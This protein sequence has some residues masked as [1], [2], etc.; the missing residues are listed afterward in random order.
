MYIRQDDMQMP[1]IACLSS[2]LEPP[3]DESSY[4][5]TGRYSGTLGIPGMHMYKRRRARWEGSFLDTVRR[6]RFGFATTTT[7]AVRWEMQVCLYFGVGDRRALYKTPGVW[8]CE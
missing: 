5:R 7:R 1:G 3:S 4:M 2:A 8:P 6:P